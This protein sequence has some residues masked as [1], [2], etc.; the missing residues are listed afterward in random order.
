MP[1]TILATSTLS[2]SPER[3]M[4]IW[5]RR[6]SATSKPC[7]SIHA[8]EVYTFDSFPREYRLAQLLRA[9]AEAELQNWEAAHDAYSRA[10]G[11]E[12]L[13]LAVNAG[14][15]SLDEVLKESFDGAVRD[16]FLLTRLSRLAE[17][18]VVIERG[19]AR[20]LAESLALDH[21][22]DPSIWTM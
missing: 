4:R 16:G 11:A 8:L 10:L 18:A 15:I 14:I 21:I 17:A 5:M 6:L 12:D 22:I 3:S 2:E 13:L 1:S 7:G 9:F 19:R 20:G